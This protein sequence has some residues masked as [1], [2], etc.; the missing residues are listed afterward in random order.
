M[1]QGKDNYRCTCCGKTWQLDNGKYG[2]HDYYVYS[3]DDGDCLTRGFTLYR[4]RHNNSHQKLVDG[5]YGPHVLRASPNMLDS[6]FSNRLDWYL[7]SYHT[8]AVTNTR[9]YYHVSGEDASETHFRTNCARCGKIFG[10]LSEHETRGGS[11]WKCGIAASSSVTWATPSQ[12]AQFGSISMQYR[13][14]D[15]QRHLERI[16]G[17]G[18]YDWDEDDD[19][20]DDDDW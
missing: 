9:S 11:H 5:D 2:N 17:G 1:T 14:V 18:S 19:Y 4:C 7:G 3:K 13:L 8:P 15:N 10:L 16:S 20:D 6:S 12:V